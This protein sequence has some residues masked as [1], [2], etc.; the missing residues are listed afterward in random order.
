MWGDIVAQEHEPQHSCP[1]G[2]KSSLN[3][4]SH[5]VIPLYLSCMDFNVLLQLLL[6][7]SLQSRTVIFSTF[8]KKTKAK[9]QGGFT[10][11]Q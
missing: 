5:S 4:I 8:Q 6:K 1:G 9:K 2:R 7:M 3:T 10:S 11:K